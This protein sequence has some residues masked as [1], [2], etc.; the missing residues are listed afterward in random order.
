MESLQRVFDRL[1][2]KSDKKID[3]AELLE[4]LR[5]L[6]YDCKKRD[7]EDMIWEVDE[8]CDK[9]VSWDEFKLM[10]QRCRTDRV[11]AQ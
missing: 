3:S 6:K 7:V 5:F 4:Y 10:F 9:C 8:D 11:S 1:D 2:T